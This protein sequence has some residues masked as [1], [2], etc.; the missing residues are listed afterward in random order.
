MGRS[1]EIEGKHLRVIEVLLDE[2]MVVLEDASDISEWQE[3]QFGNIQRRRNK[4][5]PIPFYSE[6]GAPT[7]HPVIA[8]FFASE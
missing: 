2:E 3:N 5:Y 6:L 4:T 1:A 7:L 8:L